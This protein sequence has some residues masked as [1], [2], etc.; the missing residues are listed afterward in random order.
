MIDYIRTHYILLEYGYAYV[1]TD[2]MYVVCAVLLLNDIPK[3]RKETIYKGFE[4]LLVF[5]GLIALNSIYLRIVGVYNS[6]VVMLIFLFLYAAFFSKYS[7]STRI[8]MSSIFYCTNLQ[9]LSIS[10]AITEVMRENGFSLAGVTNKI[11]FTCFIVVILF[12]LILALLKRFTTERYNFI[13]Q[14]YVVLILAISIISITIFNLEIKDILDKKYMVVISLSFWFIDTLSYMMFYINTKEYNEKLNLMLLQ[15]KSI[16]KREQFHISMKT[17]EDMR[18]LRHELKNYF[19]YA[20]ILLGQK[21][22]SKLQSYFETFKE[23][24]TDLVQHIDCGNYII[25]SCIN[26]MYS[27]AK[28]KGFKLETD[29]AVPKELPIIE[30]ELYSLLSNIIENAIEACERDKQRQAVIKVNIRQEQGYL[31][32]KVSNPIKIRVN[33]EE[34]LELKTLK[35]NKQMH[36]FGTKIIKMIVAQNNGIINFNIANGEFIVEAMLESNIDTNM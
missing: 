28:E 29:I 8:V 11:D 31:L 14:F 12:I 10:S 9:A 22:Y 4:I 3:K 15:S 16:S 33:T 18:V 6:Q 27:K 1:F 24:L 5:L 2:I 34:I 13:P 21:E 17:Y 25:N 26:Y 19:S 23:K 20:D 32:I 7:L 35:A 36:G 30:S